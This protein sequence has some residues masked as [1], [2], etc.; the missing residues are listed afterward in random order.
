MR[1]LEIICP[2]ILVSVL[3]LPT[4]YI[5]YTDPR[6]AHEEPAKFALQ[7]SAFNPLTEQAAKL[8][9]YAEQQEP[10]PPSP[11]PP[12]PPPPFPAGRDMIVQSAAEPNRTLAGVTSDDLKRIE[13]Y[14]PAGARI[15]TYPVSQSTLASALISA[16][17]DGDGEAET[18]VVYND[19]KPT[20]EEG[21]LPLTLSVLVRHKRDV[22]LRASVRLSGDVFFSPR[23]TGLGPPLAARDVTGDGHPEIIVVSGAGASLGGAL[24]V[25][26]FEGSSLHELARIDGHFF[27]L[28]SGGNGKPS[29][30]TAQ[31]RYETARRSYQW[32]GKS[33]KEA[34]KRPTK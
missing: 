9:P 20:T 21:S 17:L 10:P 12:P 29:T 11:P 7:A 5:N 16:D 2:I 32:T 34:Y 18:I 22:A 24:Q 19:R 6:G 8:E 14:L 1:T 3:E 33:F 23:I 13:R 30:I 25:F 4:A 15:Y 31:S 26:S 27:Q 28:R